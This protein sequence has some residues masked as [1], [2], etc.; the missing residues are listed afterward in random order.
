MSLEPYRY[1][2]LDS[3]GHLYNGQWL[4]VQ[5][6]EEAVAIIAAKHPDSKCEVWQ[7]RRLVATLSPKRLSA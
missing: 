1:S 6:D 5:S 4:D 2:C 3:T 7:G